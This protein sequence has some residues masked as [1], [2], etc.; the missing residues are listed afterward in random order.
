MLD[1]TT[2]ESVT[3][4]LIEVH[5]IA[6]LSLPL[7]FIGAL[8]LS[9]KLDSAGHTAIVPLTFYGFGIA[10]LLSCVIFDGLVMPGLARQI[11]EAVPEARQG[12]RIAFNAN[13]VVATAF[14][15]VFQV[16]LSLAMILWSVMIVRKGVLSRSLGYFGLL[17]GASTLLALFGGHLDHSHH[18]FAL[19]IFLQNVWLIAAG[20]ALALP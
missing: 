8:G 12:W 4:H 1:S 9:R 7:W 17:V 15:D 16:A 6:L 13:E 11:V 20:I 14:M 2:Y 5:S 10:A 19:S 3:R 18:A